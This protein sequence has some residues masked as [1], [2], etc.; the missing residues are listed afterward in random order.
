MQELQ[1]GHA[2]HTCGT[3]TANPIYSSS[4]YSIIKVNKKSTGES[5]YCLVRLGNLLV[6]LL[7]CCEPRD[8]LG[9]LND[10]VQI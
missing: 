2:G 3:T 4:Y 7:S 10:Q 1:P 9:A 8:T 5:E 6:G